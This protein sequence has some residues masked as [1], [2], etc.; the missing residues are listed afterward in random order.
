VS[1][2]NSY[3]AKIVV[4][5]TINQ[6]NP[7]YT[8]RKIFCSVDGKWN[9]TQLIYSN[10]SNVA[11]APVAPAVDTLEFRLYTPIIKSSH[12]TTKSLR[13]RKPIRF[14]LVALHCQS[15]DNNNTCQEYETFLSRKS[16]K[17]I[18]IRLNDHNTFGV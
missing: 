1:E 5:N 3:G 16:L 4:T 13:M 10:V 14:A 18:V 2:K 6:S 8:D 9:G 17:K 11:N 15:G 7:R 12:V